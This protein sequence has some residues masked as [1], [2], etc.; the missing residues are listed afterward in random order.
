MSKQMHVRPPYRVA[1]RARVVTVESTHASIGLDMDYRDCQL[2]FDFEIND[3]V[4][5]ATPEFAKVFAATSPAT[6]FSWF[7]PDTLVT[8]PEY[9]SY[10]KERYGK[11]EPAPGILHNELFTFMSAADDLDKAA[12]R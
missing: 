6:P 12:R 2:D 10:Y 3:D 1:N 7:A 5:N 9:I 11:D 8:T 4:G